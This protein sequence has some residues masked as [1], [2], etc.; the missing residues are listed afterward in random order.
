MEATP[1]QRNLDS[2]AAIRR[3]KIRRRKILTAALVVVVIAVIVFVV[4]GRLRKKDNGAGAMTTA[5]VQRADIQQVISATGS[6]TAQTG[7]QVNIGSQITGRIKRL[8]AD[9]GSRVQAGQVIAELDLPDM[10]AQLDQA[11][12]SLQSSRTQLAQQMSGVGLQ[13]TNVNSDIAKAR[14]GVDSAQA[15]YVQAQQNTRSQVSAAQAAVTQAQATAKNAQMFLARNQQLLAKG[16]IAAQDV[17]N[18]KAQADVAVAQLDSA[19]QNL[20][21]TRT[22]TQAALSTAFSSLQDAKAILAA[23]RAETANNAIK[24]EQVAQARAAV[25]QAQA[26][27]A[28]WNAQ[29]DKTVIRTPISGTVIALDVQQGETIAAGLSAPTLIRVVDLNRLQVDALVDETDI[30]NVRL[31]QRATVTVD[32]Y[33]NR[34]FAAHVVK[35]ASGST[36]QQNVVTYDTTL[37]LDNPGGLLKPDMTAT[38]K[39]V[40]GE[41]TDVLAVP[42]E[43]VKTTTNGQTVYVLRGDK[44][45]T[46]KVVTGVSNDTVTQVV[47]GLREGDT[48]VLAGYEPQAQFGPRMSPFGPGTGRPSGARGGGRGGGG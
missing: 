17:D 47:K 3:G 31:G 34:E 24:T 44:V 46:R 43:A 35:I 48:V 37:S 7:A 8:L 32:A 40:V 29:W 18:V 26:Q 2:A 21:T 36:L 33:P 27:V 12:A 45:T 16:Y 25:A 15:A 14:A 23:A 22:T 11:I 13:Q 39:I 38:A 41:H 42:I 5:T 1:N 6:V 28:Y 10:K 4:V 19:E 30:G 9:V 20:T